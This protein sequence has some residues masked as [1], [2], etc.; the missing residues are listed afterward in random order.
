MQLPEES[1][2]LKHFDPIEYATVIMGFPKIIAVSD[3]CLL[4]GSE[5]IA[6]WENKT[7]FLPYPPHEELPE[8]LSLEKHT[9][10]TKLARS[11]LVTYLAS[12]TD[13]GRRHF[14]ILSYFFRLN[15]LNFQ[16]V[17][18]TYLR[19]IRPAAGR[20]GFTQ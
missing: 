1:N 19:W 6:Q 8:G 9:T 15:F 2:R 18:M 13:D 14:G 4:N 7:T 17:P 11:K 12:D 16:D 20:A 5:I 10:N 3:R